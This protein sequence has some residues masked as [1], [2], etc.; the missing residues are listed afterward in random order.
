MSGETILD[1]ILATKREEVARLLA[2]PPTPEQIA[3]VTQLPPTRGFHNA[4]RARAS[5]PDASPA[6]IA[7][8][9][10]ASPSKGIIRAD[11]EPV[12]LAKAYEAGGA[13]CLSVLTDETYFHGDLAYLAQIRVAVGLP[14]LRKDFLIHEQQIWQARMAG[15]DAIL[16]IVAALPDSAILRTMRLLAESLDMEALVEVHDS[17]ELDVALSS[18]ATL[19]G[20]N[21]RN[22]HTFDVRL[23]TTL[24]LLSRIPET[25]TVVSESG[26]FTHDDARRLRD[27]G[28]H[29]ILVGESLMRA[30]DVARATRRLLRS[31]DSTYVD[32]ATTASW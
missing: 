9:K 4:L 31:D 19:I 6:L 2:S 24:D 18:G 29:A 12:A 27:A 23:E 22:L 14:L 16:L 20:I 28:A 25:V 8:V 1:R 26:I 32:F 21:N 5:V 17:A 10:K 15:A 11:F 13:T 3:I 30:D 7:E